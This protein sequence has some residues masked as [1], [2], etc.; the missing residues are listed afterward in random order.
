M[1]VKEEIEKRLSDAIKQSGLTQEYIA[2]TLGIKLTKVVKYVS[3][4]SLPRVNT[5]ANLCAL[6]GISA[7]EILGIK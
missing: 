7:S 6:L 5:F 1:I 2:E 4:K 3:G